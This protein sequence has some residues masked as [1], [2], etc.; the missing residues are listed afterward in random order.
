[1]SLFSEMLQLKNWFVWYADLSWLD[2]IV[3]VKWYAKYL[4]THT[5]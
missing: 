5:A 1:M 4:E 2:K 3:R